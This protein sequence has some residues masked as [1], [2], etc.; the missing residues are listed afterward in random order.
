MAD[1]PRNG[2][3][4]NTFSK[5]QRKPTTLFNPE[6][7]PDPDRKLTFKQKIRSRPT[8]NSQS[9]WALMFKHINFTTNCV[10][11]FVFF[12]D[13]QRQ[14]L[15]NIKKKSLRFLLILTVSQSVLTVLRRFSFLGRNY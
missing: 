12:S 14:K 10:I 4:K 6:T 7:D 3:E 1:W 13:R 15:S 11:I 9:R 5:N 2:Q 8:S